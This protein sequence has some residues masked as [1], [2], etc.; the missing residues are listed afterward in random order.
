MTLAPK[1]AFTKHKESVLKAIR[2]KANL[3]MFQIKKGL[4]EMLDLLKKK[5]QRN[6]GR[7][8]GKVTEK[9]EASA[10]EKLK[11]EEAKATGMNIQSVKNR[12]KELL[13]KRNHSKLVNSLKKSNLIQNTA[14]S[15]RQSFYK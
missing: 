14:K 7:K 10:V 15:T 11:R 12:K 8:E 13:F 4:A 2:F 6:G 3:G 1:N 9:G 5:R